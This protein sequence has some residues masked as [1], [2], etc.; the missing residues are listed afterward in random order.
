MSGLE[1]VP[2][3]EDTLEALADAAGIWVSVRRA[4]EILGLDPDGQRRK[5][6]GKPWAITEMKSVIDPAGM[7]RP[8]FFIDL[9]SFPMWLAT[10]E[11]SRVAPAVRPKLERYQR[12]AKQVLA[13]HFLRLRPAAAPSGG[14]VGSGGVP[15]RIDPLAVVDGLAAVAAVIR[16]DRALF[17]TKVAALE[18]EAKQTAGAVAVTQADVAGLQMQLARVTHEGVRFR[19][20]ARFIRKAAAHISKECKRYCWVRGG[21][22]ALFDEC[23]RDLQLPKRRSSRQSI[24]QS[25]KRADQALTF[26]ATATRLGVPNCSP[27]VINK[28]LNGD[29]DGDVVDMPATAPVRS[30]GPTKPSSPPLPGIVDAE[31]DDR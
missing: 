29:D 25:I 10:V 1:L 13:S 7:P 24:S 11:P 31:P 17:D 4:C 19:E 27:A 18:L 9:E 14:T 8:A 26:A 5:L 12:E 2:F 21:Y 6:K 3:G 30:P 20:H 16:A 23:R 22:Q 15:A 28:I